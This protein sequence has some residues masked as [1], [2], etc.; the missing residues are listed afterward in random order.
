MAEP[1]IDRWLTPRV[2]LRVVLALVLFTLVLEWLAP[3][4]RGGER[5]S[6]LTSYS[7]EP[8]GV[9]GLYETLGRLGWR[10]ERRE[11]PLRGVLDTIATYIVM[12]PEVDPTAAE[13]GALL[14]AVR[15]GAALLFVPTPESALADSLQIEQSDYSPYPL[16]V[17]EPS[18]ARENEDADD[19]GWQSVR[20]TSDDGGPLAG[21]RLSY[22][23]T[24]RARKPLP[25]DTVGFLYGRLTEVEPTPI[26][27]GIPLGRG[28]LV[29]V[30]DPSLFRNFALREANGGLLPVRLVEW[31]ARDTPRVVFDEFHQGFGHHPSVSRSVRRALAHTP[32]GRTLLQL[33]AAGLILLVALSVRPIAPRPRLRTERRSPFEHVGAL[34]RAYEQIGATRLAA[35]RLIRGLRRR[36]ALAT[37]GDDD[38]AALRRL[39]ARH[40]ALKPDVERLLD[41]TTRRL[42]PDEFRQI[43]DSIATME[44]TLAP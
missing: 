31:L 42:P 27:L 19:E 37:A 14:A 23:Y 13:V 44:R 4:G 11:L 17:G 33:L 41:A 5:A 6:I 36:H 2:V 7:Y 8:G 21:R 15:R 43:A 26:I 1:T 3:A 25:P 40:P 32:A 34:A 35:R 10:V 12:E 30:A 9:R 24:L 22:H 29:A 20:D 28:R 39:V 16:R 38:E 18:A